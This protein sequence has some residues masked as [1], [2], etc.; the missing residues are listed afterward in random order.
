MPFTLK[1]LHTLIT[2]IILV[3]SVPH[4]KILKKIINLLTCTFKTII[5]L[6]LN[7]RFSVLMEVT[8]KYGE[9]GTTYKIQETF[10]HNEK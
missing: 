8:L 2:I 5:N 9:F 3:L 10:T 6:N 7:S 4:L 1:I